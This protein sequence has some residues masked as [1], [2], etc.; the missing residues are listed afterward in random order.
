MQDLKNV[1]QA[2]LRG[3]WRYRW[4]ALAVAWLV[5]ALGWTAVYLTPDMYEARSSFYLDTSSALQPFVKELSVGLNFDEQVDLIKQLVL[6]RDTLA[7]VAGKANFRIDELSPQE[8]AGVVEGLRSRIQL[9][10]GRRAFR[11]ERDMNFQIAYRD[12]DRNR[13]VKV[14]QLVLDSF[15]EDTLKLRNEGFQSAQTFLK[16]QVREQE[17]RLGEAERRLA[18]FKRHNI[19]NLPTR[20]GSY[21]QSLQ[22]EMNT[23]QELESQARVLQSRR[24]QLSQQL[25]QERQY[26]PSSAVPSLSGAAQA[27][28]GNDVESRILA[29]Q[30]R[31]EELLRKYTPKHPEVIALEDSLR[32]LRDERQEELLRLGIRDVPEGDGL[33]ANPAYEQI[34]LQRNQ[35]DVEIAA[36]RGQIAER[37]ER[38]AE[39]RSRMETMPEVEAELLQLNRDYDVLRDRYEAMVKQLETA[40]LSDAVGQTDTVEFSILEPPSA[41][42]APVAPPRTLLLFAIF[43]AG[44]G[45]GTLV[46]FGMSRLNPVFDTPSALRDATGLPV[47]GSVTVTWLGRR[48]ERRRA[49]VARV[50]IAGTALVIVF[51]LVFFARNAGSRIIHGL[52]G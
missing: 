38:I 50:A 10:G 42:S 1:V 15:I 45:A 35:I 52:L 32:Q 36:V 30:T 18:E 26:L 33:V 6:S 39:M 11:G 29:A 28:S 46:A 24:A 43:V 19:D 48:K 2:E 16:E 40:K 17:R 12:N 5:C 25:M 23:L 49:E 3:A 8:A 31:L 4:Q 51:G 34:R 37:S 7:N 13:A 22:A 47:L 27:L 41:L 44:L 14:V 20:E 21:V 9:T